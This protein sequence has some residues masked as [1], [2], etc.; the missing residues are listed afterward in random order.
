M[1]QGS[2]SPMWS[3]VVPVS[4]RRAKSPGLPQFFVLGA[5]WAAHP[6]LCSSSQTGFHFRMLQ[7]AH[8]L[9][10]LLTYRSSRL[11]KGLST[12]VLTERF[13]GLLTLR[14]SSG[15]QVKMYVQNNDLFHRG[16]LHL[17]ISLPIYIHMT[18]TTPCMS[19]NSSDIVLGPQENSRMLIGRKRLGGCVWYR[20]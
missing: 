12:G 7:A 11:L 3:G 6:N 13:S 10:R 16:Y 2:K 18:N 15:V 9:R 5:G 20:G 17:H 1:A 8:E 19:I 4:F 14:S